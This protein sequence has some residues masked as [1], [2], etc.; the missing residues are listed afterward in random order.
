MSEIKNDLKKALE[1]KKNKQEEKKSQAFLNKLGKKK[2]G[3]QCRKMNF[4]K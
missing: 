4:N 3:S 1:N 2:D